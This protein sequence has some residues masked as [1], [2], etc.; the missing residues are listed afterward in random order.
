MC[1]E[2]ENNQTMKSII[3]GYKYLTTYY[4]IFMEITYEV[5]T[6]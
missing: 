1:Y 3:C 2:C 6:C 4:I 5:H